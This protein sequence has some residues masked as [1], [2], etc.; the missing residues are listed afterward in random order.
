MDGHIMHCGTIGSCQ[1]AATF[2]IVKR[3]WSWVLTRVSGAITSV[4]TFTF[5]IWATAR[6][7]QYSF[8]LL[9][10]VYTRFLKFRNKCV[11]KNFYWNVCYIY[12]VC[13]IP[14]YFVLSKIRSA[15]DRS[16]N[17]PTPK[18]ETRTIVIQYKN[19]QSELSGAYALVRTDAR[20]NI[21]F[22]ML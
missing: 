9:F 19:V 18:A 12:H 5:I 20:C 7:I 13:V 10:N 14:I 16:E 15:W 21:S 1:S 2:E 4:Q 17:V 11:F 3:C 6:T 22:E 8:S